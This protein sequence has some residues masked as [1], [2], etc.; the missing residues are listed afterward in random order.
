MT[1][2]IIIIIIIIITTTTTTTVEEQRL[3]FSSSRYFIGSNVLLGSLFSNIHCVVRFKVL[4]ATNMKMTI[5]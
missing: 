2:I 5:F 1:L 4:M 3:K